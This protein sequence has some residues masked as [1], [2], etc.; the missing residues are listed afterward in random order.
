MFSLVHLMKFG[1]KGVGKYV[2]GF[3]NYILFVVYISY[4]RN[5]RKV[6]KQKYS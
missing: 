3:K 6:G 4:M 2:S 1:A 5:F